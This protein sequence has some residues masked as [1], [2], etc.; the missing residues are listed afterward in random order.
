MR[1][2][3]QKDALDITLTE[4]G[5][6]KLGVATKDAHGNLRIAVLIDEKVV[7]APVVNQ[8]VT[9]L[10]YR[11]APEKRNVSFEMRPDGIAV[12]FSKGEMVGRGIDTSNAPREG[13]PAKGGRRALNAVLPE[14]D[15]SRKDFDMV[16]WV[17]EIQI[18][19]KEG[20]ISLIKLRDFLNPC[21]FGKRQFPVTSDAP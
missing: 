19:H 16:R 5:G 18:L 14:A 10:R 20:E 4:E 17:E 6:K 21:L 3:Q 11:L 7:L 13:K 8:R 9:G 12:H 2:L 1:S 15:F